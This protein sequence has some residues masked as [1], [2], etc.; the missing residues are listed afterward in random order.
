MVH[1]I[2]RILIFFNLLTF[3]ETQ[4]LKIKKKKLYNS[5]DSNFDKNA[6]KESSF[7]NF[8]QI[9]KKIKFS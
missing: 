9:W 4:A 5:E 1:L 6:F 8:F 2:L 3:E 7:S